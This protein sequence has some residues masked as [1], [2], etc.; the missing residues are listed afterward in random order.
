MWNIVSIII[1][2]L[3]IGSLITFF[4]TR[5]DAKKGLESKI[6]KLEKDSV[7]MQILLLMFYYSE[8]KQIK[9]NF[10]IVQSI[11]SRKKTRVAWMVIGTY[12]QCSRDSWTATALT[13]QL[14]LSRRNRGYK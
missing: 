13:F 11:I 4:V 6:H 8:E 14:G 5:Y 1:G 2:G 3:G 7:R 10:L 9:R 12:L